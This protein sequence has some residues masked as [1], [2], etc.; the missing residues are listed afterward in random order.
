VGTLFGAA[1]TRTKAAV[2]LGYGKFIPVVFEGE[3]ELRQDE[4]VY[5]IDADTPV[6]PVYVS[7]GLACYRSGAVWLDHRERPRKLELRAGQILRP[8]PKEPILWP[9]TTAGVYAIAA[10]AKMLVE[11]PGQGGAQ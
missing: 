6:N 11:Y 2:G 7:T 1:V 5:W 3:F 8:F 10:P 9:R 4:M